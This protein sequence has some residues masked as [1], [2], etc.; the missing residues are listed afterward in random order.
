MEKQSSHRDNCQPPAALPFDHAG[1]LRD[2]EHF[3]MM[4]P[5][6]HPHWLGEA[7][8][9]RYSF[10][11]LPLHWPPVPLWVHLRS[12]GTFCRPV[13]AAVVVSLVHEQGSSPRLV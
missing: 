5:A 3:V 9:T 1:P 6:P 8:C 7:P 13:S 11:S 2:V 12:S 4:L 10:A